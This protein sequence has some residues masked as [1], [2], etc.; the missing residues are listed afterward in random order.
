MLFVHHRPRDSSSTEYVSWILN[1]TLTSFSPTV[2]MGDF[3]VQLNQANWL[4]SL[5]QTHGYRQHI[6]QVTTRAFTSIDGVFARHD[7]PAS[8]L[9]APF[10]FHRPIVASI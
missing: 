8:V 10:S 5:L 7:V 6:S 9:E 2:I 4:S 1:D 3:N